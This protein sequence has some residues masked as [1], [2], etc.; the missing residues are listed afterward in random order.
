MIEEVVCTNRRPECTKKNIPK[1]V[2]STGFQGSRTP[3]LA[4]AIKKICRSG[5]KAA[6]TLLVVFLGGQILKKMYN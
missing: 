5:F 4:E 1:K 2:L 3:W 6:I